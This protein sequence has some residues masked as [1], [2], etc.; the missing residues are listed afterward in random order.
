[1]SQV[2]LQEERPKPA[3]AS[4]AEFDTTPKTLAEIW[5]RASRELTQVRGEFGSRSK[6]QACAAGAIVFYLPRDGVDDHLGLGNTTPRGID[7][8]RTANHL[9][10]DEF[11]P[12]E[13]IPDKNDRGHW[14]FA[15][16]ATWARVKGI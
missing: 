15:D 12:T 5:E 3:E 2:L 13:G 9:M 7:L 14:T 10:T 1:M 16:F 6:K 4:L 8:M 11:G